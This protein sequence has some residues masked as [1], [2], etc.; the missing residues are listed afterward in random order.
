MGKVELIEKF[1]SLFDEKKYFETKY[2]FHDECKVYIE[3]S[4]EVFDTVDLWLQMNHDYPGNWRTLLQR[5]DLIDNDAVSLAHVFS[6]DPEE[7]HYVT[8]F[9]KFKDGLI[10]EMKEYW[11]V[12]EGQPEWRKKYSK[13][14]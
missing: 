4:R 2:L 14:Y 12:I 13:T 6:D 10:F 3:N 11:G 7:E 9:Y 5:C 1:W 8:T